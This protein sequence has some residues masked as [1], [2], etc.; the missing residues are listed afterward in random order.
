[1]NVIFF[2]SRE[3]NTSVIWP[4]PRDRMKTNRNKP[5]SPIAAGIIVRMFVEQC[6]IDRDPD[7]NRWFHRKLRLR[8]GG[9]RIIEIEIIPY[10]KIVD[11]W[12][13]IC[14]ADVAC[15]MNVTSEGNEAFRILCAGN[16]VI[17][18]TPKSSTETYSKGLRKPF[19][20]EKEFI[21]KI[22]RPTSVSALGTYILNWCSYWDLHVYIYLLTDRGTKIVE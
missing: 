17:E 5:P 8:F 6:R 10:E 16:N 4:L 2:S 19:R 9:R 21:R 13:C 1:M 12:C 11:S 15:R 3:D 20:F 18:N 14:W 22:S 7:K